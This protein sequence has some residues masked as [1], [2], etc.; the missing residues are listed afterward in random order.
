MFIGVFGPLR[1]KYRAGFLNRVSQVRILP[2]ALTDTTRQGCRLPQVTLEPG[3]INRHLGPLR[4]TG[5]EGVVRGQYQTANL[6]VDQMQSTT[7]FGAESLVDDERGCF[8]T[9]RE[10]ISGAIVD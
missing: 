8:A 5:E 1:P 2:R 7:R 9:V 6:S 3:E 10:G 4:R